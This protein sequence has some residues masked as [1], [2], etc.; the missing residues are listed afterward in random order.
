[1]AQGSNDL[2]TLPLKSNGSPISSVVANL[3]HFEKGALS[4]S[5]PLRPRVWKRYV[6][7]VFSILLRM[8]VGGFLKHINSIDG[9]IEFT[10]KEESNGR[11][12]FL[13][14]S[15][16]RMDPGFLVMSVFFA[17]KPTPTEF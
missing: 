8:D 2:S 7:A 3:E 14:V 6:D 11:L 5:G 1:M 10:V 15:I 12:P 4:S 9:Q 17:S 16:D 13:D